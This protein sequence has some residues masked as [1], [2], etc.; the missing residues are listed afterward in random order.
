MAQRW[1]KSDDTIRRRCSYGLVYELSK[2]QSK[3]YADDFFLS[4]IEK[5][6]A[7]FSDEAKPERLAMGGAL[8]GIGKRSAALNQAAV[9]LARKIGPIDFNEEGQKCDPLDVV[10]HLD[11]DA[12]RQKL[13]LS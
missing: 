10:K 13:G 7:T 5:I 4:V 9:A 1:L 3:L 8:L 2:K 6:D 11:N 12:L